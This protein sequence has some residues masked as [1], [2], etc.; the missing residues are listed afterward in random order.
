MTEAAT[1]LK[2]L[3]QGDSFFPSGSLIFS[4]GLETLAEEGLITTV[5]EVAQFLRSQIFGRWAD[6]DRPLVAG[7]H[8]L[9]PD[10]EAVAELDRLVEAQMLVRELREGSHKV[11]RALLG[12]HSRLETAGAAAYRD[13]VIA[14]EAPGH[15]TVVQG[16]LWRAVR[17]GR[18]DALLLSAHQLCVG[19]LGAA[20]RLGL[21]GHI[22]T[23]RIFASLH[24]DIASIVETR[25]LP[26]PL[27][28]SS[29]CP[30]A[31]IAVM[32][33]ETASSR[34]FAN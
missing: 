29:F 17:L 31:D 34:L 8:D 30:E 1:L 27:E 6:F 15:A 33:H 25:P 16:L 23:Q 2:L 12:V 5:D 11:G 4:G 21:I 26:S 14:G 10:L 3:Q 32:R 22:D 19:L 9:A 20:L 7:A 18:R 24:L 28:I 13:L